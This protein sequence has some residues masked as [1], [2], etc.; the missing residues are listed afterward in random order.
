M[1]GQ[2]ISK[3]RAMKTLQSAKLS[4]ANPYYI[5]S[6]EK[7]QSLLNLGLNLNLK[8]YFIHVEFRS[9]RYALHPLK[10]ACYCLVLLQ[11]L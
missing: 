4:K 6:H 7:V 8:T 11:A 10:S 3:E 2:S 5:I 9:R 1:N